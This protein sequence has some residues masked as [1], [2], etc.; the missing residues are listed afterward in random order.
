[1]PENSQDEISTLTQACL[2]LISQVAAT[3]AVLCQLDKVVR[4][5]LNL[6]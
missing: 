4:E 2:M 5:K 3:Q 6:R 1:M